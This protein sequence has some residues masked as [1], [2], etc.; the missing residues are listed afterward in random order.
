MGESDPKRC[1]ETDAVEADLVDGPAH[2]APYSAARAWVGGR[3]ERIVT[4]SSAAVG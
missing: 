4:N 3:F 1:E 2:L